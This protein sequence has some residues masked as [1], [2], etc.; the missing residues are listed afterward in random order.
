MNDLKR[1][2][3]LAAEILA[4]TRT[5][6]T[7]ADEEAIYSAARHTLVKYVPQIVDELEQS[8]VN[9]ELTGPLWETLIATAQLRREHARG[10]IEERSKVFHLVTSSDAARSLLFA[11]AKEQLSLAAASWPGKGG[12]WESV[13]QAVDWMEHVRAMS[14]FSVFFPI[15]YYVELNRQALDLVLRILDD[16]QDVPGTPRDLSVRQL[17]GLELRVAHPQSLAQA[18]IA[19]ATGNGKTP[20]WGD[21]SSPAI[22]ELRWAQ[23]EE[24]K[25][26]SDF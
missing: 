14:A 5:S 20:L 1:N 25:G 19:A 23:L 13:E 18:V 8:V 4:R 11:E 12:A 6:Q 2:A 22:R 3:R 15:R 21:L 17:F 7:P 9:G 26:R 24:Q 10:V 16:V